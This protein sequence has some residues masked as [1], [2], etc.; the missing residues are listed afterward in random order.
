ML[1]NEKEVIVVDCGAVVY[2]MPTIF[3]GV[4]VSDLVISHLLSQFDHSKHAKSAKMTPPDKGHLSLT[5]GV[6]NWHTY[7]PY[8][9][10]NFG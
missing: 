2:G 9:F 1:G 10:R 6:K 5:D 7:S 8:S 3:C 4:M